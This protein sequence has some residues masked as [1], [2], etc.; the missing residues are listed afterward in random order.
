MPVL[1]KGLNVKRD[2]YK[3]R[4]L[5]LHYFF[6]LAKRGMWESITKGAVGGT[7]MRDLF[8]K[9][10]CRRGG[11]HKHPPL[12]FGK[13]KAALGPKKVFGVGRRSKKR[14]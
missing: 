11:S 14:G 8:S 7:R 9:Q 1:G 3:K 6:F 5:L 13:M 12:L 4:I 10:F 2:K